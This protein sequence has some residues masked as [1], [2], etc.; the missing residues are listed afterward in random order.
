M[1][2]TEEIVKSPLV[3]TTE[4]LTHARNLARQI[5][6]HVRSGKYAYAYFGG[7]DGDATRFIRVKVQY[8]ESE[9][10]GDRYEFRV[11]SLATGKW[12]NLSAFTNIKLTS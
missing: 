2:Y 10:W 12:V 5:N 9:K 7:N 6:R 3:R 11:Y 4:E 8:F 1:S